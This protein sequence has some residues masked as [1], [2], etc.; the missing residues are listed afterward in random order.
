MFI[1]LL[2]VKVYFTI[3][4]LVFV[5]EPWLGAF[6][7]LNY[8]CIYFISAYIICK[9]LWWII[10]Y[11]TSPFYEKTFMIYTTSNIWN[12]TCGIL[13]TATPIKIRM[14]PRT[15]PWF[16]DSPLTLPVW[17]TCSFAGILILVS[18]GFANLYKKKI[19]LITIIWIFKQAM[20]PVFDCRFS[21]WILF[22]TLLSMLITPEWFTNYFKR[23]STVFVFF[24][25]H[26]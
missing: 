12:F 1:P 5:E 20:E 23:M 13:D 11:L 17:P 22:K 10:L 3:S 16:R 21:S 25:I 24:K 8:F 6:K 4:I 26:D 9:I 7:N 19:M 18:L 2:F 15:T 14:S